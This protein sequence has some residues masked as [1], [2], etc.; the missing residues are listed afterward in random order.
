MTNFGTQHKTRNQLPSWP[1]L[2]EYQM[3]KTAAKKIILRLLGHYCK[4][5]LKIIMPNYA[6]QNVSPST[7]T[8]S[9]W[10]V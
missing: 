6:R 10:T 8:N 7:L 9:Q 3:M 5:L 4:Q 2:P 1:L